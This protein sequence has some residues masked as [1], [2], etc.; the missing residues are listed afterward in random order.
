VR[1]LAVDAMELLDRQIADLGGLIALALAL[2]TVFT[3]V[4]SSRAAARKSRTGLKRDDMVG[5]LILDGLLVALTVGVILAATPLVVGA[6]EHLAIGH[7]RGALRLTFA[8]V[9]LLLIGLA[10]WQLTILRATI[11]T[12]CSVWSQ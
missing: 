5:E 6:F 7:Q 11:E 12:A 3:T 9:W 1:L 2:V 10:V 4:R 8:V